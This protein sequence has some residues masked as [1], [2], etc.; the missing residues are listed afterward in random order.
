MKTIVSFHAI[1]FLSVATNLNA[2]EPLK[3]IVAI[4]AKLPNGKIS[5]GTGFFASDDGI[6]ITCYHVIEGSKNIIIN[7]SS[8]HTLDSATKEIE[9]VAVSGRYDLA[10]LRVLGKYKPSSYL[11][12]DGELAGKLTPRDNLEAYGNP[13]RIRDQNFHGSPTQK[14][15]MLSKKLNDSE[16]MPLCNLED[17]N[18]IPL[19]MTVGNGMSGCPVLKDDKVI[20]VLSGS[21]SDTKGTVRTIAWA[22]PVSYISED[23]LK[24][25]KK[26]SASPED[27]KNWPSLDLMSRNWKRLSIELPKEK[28][29]QPANNWILF[30]NNLN[31]K[32]TAWEDIGRYPSKAAA[33]EAGLKY[34]NSGYKIHVVE[35]KDGKYAAPPIVKK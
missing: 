29:K 26:L 12:L 34:S 21:L 1:V 3:A 18:L 25:F 23:G 32:K 31:D 8:K 35:I 19:D 28:E 13:Q 4:E 6:I 10:L 5:N 2:A 24:H 27:I 11:S 33:N 30:V 22:I 7:D 16:A 20:G 14:G 17:V 15:F 9:I